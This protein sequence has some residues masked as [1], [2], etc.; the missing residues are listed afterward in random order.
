MKYINEILA[1]I[2]SLMMI[3]GSLC[4]LPMLAKVVICV[5]AIL[6]GLWNIVGIFEKIHKGDKKIAKKT[7]KSKKV[8]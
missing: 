4:I 1:I 3:I 6:Y 2:V 5:V 8:A 7:R